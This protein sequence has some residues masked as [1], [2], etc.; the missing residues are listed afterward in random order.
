MLFLLYSGID[1]VKMHANI[2]LS[3]IL[4][5]SAKALWSG[6]KKVLPAFFQAGKTIIPYAR[7]AYL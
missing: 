5:D 3:D 7:R 1:I 4:A 2:G 6:R